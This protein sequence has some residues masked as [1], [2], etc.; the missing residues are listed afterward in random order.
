[1]TVAERHFGLRTGEREPPEG[2]SHDLSV[3]GR[4]Q[5][6]RSTARTDHLPNSR[7]NPTR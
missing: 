1:M 3:E 5:M 4:F 7:T 6:Q 2:S